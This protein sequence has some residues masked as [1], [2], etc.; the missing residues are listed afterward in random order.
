[1]KNVEN[2]K[3]E[4]TVNKTIISLSRKINTCLSTFWTICEISLFSPAHPL[5]GIPPERDRGWGWSAE[6]QAPKPGAHGR[7]LARG[8]ETRRKWKQKPMFTLCSLPAQQNSFKF[9][10]IVADFYRNL[11]EIRGQNDP[12]IIEFDLLRIFANSANFEFDSF[13]I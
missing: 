9:R 4:E 13:Q 1:M 2:R 11:T 7:T 12:R 8:K 10:R 6:K 5:E 3:K